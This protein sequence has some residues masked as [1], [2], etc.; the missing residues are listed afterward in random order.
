MEVGALAGISV[1]LLEKLAYAIGKDDFK[2]FSHNKFTLQLFLECDVSVFFV[3]IR[4]QIK[5]WFDAEQRFISMG[6][7]FIFMAWY[8]F[9]RQ[10]VNGSVEMCFVY[11]IGVV[12]A[13]DSL[14]IIV[15][16]AAQTLGLHCPWKALEWRHNARDGVSNHQPHDCLFSR[17]FRRR[18][19]KTSKLP[20]TGLC[21]GNSPVAGEFPEQR[22]S[23]AENVP[24]W[25]RHHGP[26]GIWVNYHI[27]KRMK[28][29]LS[30]NC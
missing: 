25:W 7:P 10:N 12:Y 15:W 20:V 27:T 3:I 23:N 17:E 14:P 19:T 26:S 22:A 2:G 28:T 9:A 30:R 21:E 18:W 5:W 8:V 6:F 29:Q 11:S 4:L 16:Y 1:S 13:C 24:I